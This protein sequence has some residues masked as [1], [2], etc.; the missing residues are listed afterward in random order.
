M[1]QPLLFDLKDRR[2]FVAG[3][4]GLVGSA[5]VRR[6]QRE[7]CEVLTAG[8][9]VLDLTRQTE[10]EDWIAANRPDAIFNAAGRVGGIYAND[11]YPANFIADNLAIGLNVVRAAHRTG[12]K[13]LMAFSSSCVYPK[14]APQPMPEEALMT[15]PMEPTSEW[16]ALA[17]VAAIKLCQAY[18]KQHGDDFICVV[19]NNLY[20]PGDNFHPQNSHVAPGLMRRFHEAKLAGAESVTV[21][22]SGRQ[23]RDFLASDDLADACIFLMKHYS[24]ADALNIGSGS[25]VTIGEF[26]QAIAEV[27]GCKAKIIFDTTEPDGAPRKLL[28]T[29]RITGLGWRPQVDMRTGLAQAYADFLAGGGRSTV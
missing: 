16:Y 22:G 11:T 23:R 15:G 6:L 3:H 14:L 20:G 12:V 26:A 13:K 21:W 17:K 25:D 10:T 8:R 27:V 7:G 9:D 19:P 28:D 29:A 5:L 1:A 18:R 2:V 4:K 24:G